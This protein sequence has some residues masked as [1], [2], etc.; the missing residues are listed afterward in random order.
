MTRMASLAMSPQGRVMG[1]EPSLHQLMP[2]S[3]AQ[4]SFTHVF[5]STWQS[6]GWSPSDLM[7]PWIVL[8]YA[9]LPNSLPHSGVCLSGSVSEGVPQGQQR[10]AA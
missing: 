2:P 4:A 3:R 10:L 6:P 9:R 8:A 5:A 7:W 1:L